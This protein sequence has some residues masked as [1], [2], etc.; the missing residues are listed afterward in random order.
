MTAAKH[1]HVAA[2]VHYY[3]C[4]H[5]LINRR[6]KISVAQS[7]QFLFRLKSLKYISTLKKVA[8]MAKLGYLFSRP[9]RPV[10]VYTHLVF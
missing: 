10:Q 6:P 3:K 5:M 9:L 2:S 7:K 4:I 8:N 1:P